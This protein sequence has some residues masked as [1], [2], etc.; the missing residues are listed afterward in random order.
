MVRYLRALAE[1]GPV[2]ASLLLELAQRLLDLNQPDEALVYARRG[3]RAAAA[4]NNAELRQAAA[5][6]I[7]RVPRP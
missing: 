6:L 7:G 1:G 3:Q 4:E 2:D 5:E